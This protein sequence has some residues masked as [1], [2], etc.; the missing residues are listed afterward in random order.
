VPIFGYIH[1]FSVKIEKSSILLAC[2]GSN[3]KL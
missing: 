2:V 3:C 1:D